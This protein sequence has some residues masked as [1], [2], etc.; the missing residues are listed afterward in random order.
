MK[1]TLVLLT[2]LLLMLLVACESETP[3]DVEVLMYTNPV[4]AS[5]RPDP[6]VVRDDDGYFYVFTTETA[7]RYIPIM[8]SQN[9]VEWEDVGNVFGVRPTWGTPGANLWAPD[10]VRIGDQYVLYYSLSTWGD[11]NPGIGV[12]TAD[13]PSGPWTDHGELF[14]SLDIGVNNSI[15]PVVFIGQ[16]ERVY[17]IWGSMR[18]LYGVELTADGL[19]LMD[20]EQAADTKVHIAGLPSHTPWNVDSYEAP[21]VI[22]HD[23]YYYLF[24]SSGTCCESLNSTYHIRVARSTSPLGPYYDRQ[25][26]DML[27]LSR[28]FMALNSSDHFVGP[29]HNAVIQDDAGDWWTLYHSFS[30]TNPNARLLMLDPLQWTD[31]GWP[32]VA[33]QNPSRGDV[34]YPHID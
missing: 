19:A 28:G 14:R 22:F 13:H 34:P 1:K 24:M 31:D 8:R 20:G 32:F 17:M 15:D 23:G 29:G 5:N 16:D 30:Q 9:L 27:D 7:G 26:R 21:Y 18:G 3:N 12:A 33:G 4:F 11:P 10:V 6:S 25:G 2:F